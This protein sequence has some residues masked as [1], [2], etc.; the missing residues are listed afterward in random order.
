MF[1]AC[2]VYTAVLNQNAVTAHLLG[3]QLPHSCFERQCS[4]QQLEKNALSTLALCYLVTIEAV[5]YN[6]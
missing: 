2:V 4:V 1:I 6:F 3:E 5:L